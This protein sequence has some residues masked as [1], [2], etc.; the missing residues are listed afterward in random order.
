MDSL[1]AEGVIVLGGPVGEDVDN[2]EALLV[3][4]LESEASVRSRL[5]EDPWA[6]SVLTIAR[7][8]P[9]S[10]WLRGS[11]GRH[12]LPAAAHAP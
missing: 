3:V 10:V 12:R 1:A 6:G 11:R 9:W 5:A 2:G 7:I 4:D 8:E